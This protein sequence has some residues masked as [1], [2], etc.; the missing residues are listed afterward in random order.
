[1][2]L[3]NEERPPAVG[4]NFTLRSLLRKAFCQALCPVFFFNKETAVRVVVHRDDFTFSGHHLELVALRNWMESWC[5]IK[6][7]GIMGSGRDDTKEIEMLGRRLWRTN[8]GLEL[9]TSRIPRLKLLRYLGLNEDSKGLSC[10]VVQGKGKE[11]EGWVPCKHEASK[12]R[13]GVALVN[14]LGQDRPD[15]QYATKQASHKMASPTETDLPRLRIARCLVEAEVVWH[16]PE[17][18]DEP[19]AV[20]AFVDSDWAGCLRTR[21]STSGGVLS[22]AGTAM[23]STERLSI[24]QRSRGPQKPSDLRRWQATSATN[25]KSSSGVIRQ[26]Q[27][28]WEPE[29]D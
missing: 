26:Q 7:R 29:K 28:V 5:D 27:E 21:I 25:S 24:M 19:D 9:E 20:E 11:E 17:T 23:K 12:F 6:F 2:A 1:M 4:N 15:V 16:F 3:R 13:G 14:F 10:P 18:V 22:M 8:K